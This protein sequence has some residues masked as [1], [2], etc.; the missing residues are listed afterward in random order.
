MTMSG[1]LPWL[2]QP[3]LAGGIDKD[4]SRA[5]ELLGLGFGSVEFGSVTALAIAGINPGVSALVARLQQLD[6][7]LPGRSAMG[8]RPRLVAR[9]LCR[10]PF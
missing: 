9:C 10:K 5:A 8:G 3:G 7:A 2:A 6:L 4:G 1:V